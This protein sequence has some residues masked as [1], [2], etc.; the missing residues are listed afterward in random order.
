[1]RRHWA[2]YTT[3]TILALIL[4]AL[5]TVVVTRPTPGPSA[6]ETTRSADDPQTSPAST[7]PVEIITVPQPKF[8]WEPWMIKTDDP[9]WQQDKRW[10]GHPPPTIVP[11]IF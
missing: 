2:W 10:A 9:N 11:P 7:A 8:S 5:T 1:M 4:A 3:A 6:D